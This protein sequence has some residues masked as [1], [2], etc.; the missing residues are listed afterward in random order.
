MRYTFLIVAAV[1]VAACTNKAT[2]VERTDI[3]NIN[4]GL[5]KKQ[6][7]Y[8]PNYSDFMDSVVSFPLETN[9]SCLIGY[10]L[11]MKMV[12]GNLYVQTRDEI[13]TFTNRGKFESKLK[14]KGRAASEYLSLR[15]FDVNRANGDIHI[16]D[17]L[18]RSIKVYSAK[19]KF[20]RSVSFENDV[21]ARDF[22]RLSDGSYFFYTPD[23]HCGARGLWQ[24]DSLGKNFKQLVTIDDDFEFCILRNHF[25][26]HISDDTISLLGHEDKNLG[27]HITPDTVIEAYKINVDVTISSK[28]SS[29]APKWDVEIPELSI[30]SKNLHLETHNYLGF[31]VIDGS[32]KWQTRV[33]YNKFTGETYQRRLTEDNDPL[34]CGEKINILVMPQWAD[35]GVLFSCLEAPLVCDNKQVFGEKFAGVTPESNP[36]VWLYYTKSGK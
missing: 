31:D 8:V 26:Q 36:C 32:N 1:T 17:D 6:T 34:V 28:V 3:P 5:A 14:R 19:G 30:Y 35:N 4:V 24:T 16:Y 21:I 7:R 33:I 13:F 20:L 12:R 27:Y 15:A 18:N 9:D 29:E 23:I 25:L 2:V 22:A 11:G 10:I